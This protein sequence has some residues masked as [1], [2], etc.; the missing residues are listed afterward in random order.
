MIVNPYA[1]SL[2]ASAVI[3]GAVALYVWLRRR[4]SGGTLFALTM[5][6]VTIWSFG[7][8]LELASTELAAMRRWVVFEYVGITT[9]PVLWLLFSLRFSGLGDRLAPWHFAALFV[10]PIVTLLLNATNERLHTLYYADVRLDASGPFPLLALTPGP[11]YWVFTGYAYLCVLGGALVL[12]YLWLHTPSLYRG[13]ATVLVLGAC[14]PLLVNVAYL[15]GLR[16]LRHVDISPLAFTATG[17]LVTFGIFRYSLFDLNPI[18]R[19]LLFEDLRDLVLVLDSR[20]RLVD[21]NAAARRALDGN[22]RA[23]PGATAANLLS[24]WPALATLCASPGEAHAEIQLDPAGEEVYDGIVTPLRDRRG[25]SAGR[26]VVLRD[27]SERRHA[28]AERREMERQVQ[29]IQKLES[30]GVLA[31][32]IAHDFN[33]LLMAIL[34][35]LDLARFDLP[36]DHP[37]RES[38][39]D[40]ERAARRAAA[41]TRQLLTYAAKGQASVS[42]I[43]LSRLVEEITQLLQ[44]SVGR[45]I[46]FDLRLTPDL[47]A[48]DG[49]PAQ[50]QQIVLNLITNASEAIDGRAGTITL[51]TGVLHADEAHLSRSRLRQKPRPGLFV[52]LTVADTGIGMDAATQERLFEPFFTTRQHGRG[53]GMSAVLGIVQRHGGAILVASEPLAGT[54]VSVLFPID[55]QPDA[56]PEATTTQATVGGA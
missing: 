21:L 34:G 48:F 29:H 12:A 40:A 3:S 13:Q 8:G 22:L 6:A 50:L 39:S 42:A 25:L 31:G 45:L 7:Y 41:L 37:A 19:N 36:H 52:Y 35:N 47:P 32:G 2:L 44:V 14:L 55:G 26:L 49:D 27:V 28:E 15:L 18:A 20:G 51:A 30:L 5:A 46:S 17:L 11:W 43:N 38:L 10:V 56:P 54:Q 23:T 4:T 33:N 24:R 9:A 53:L 16:P 1:L